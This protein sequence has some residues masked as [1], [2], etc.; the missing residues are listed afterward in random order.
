MQNLKKGMFF[1]TIGTYSNFIVQ[2]IVNMVLSRLLVPKDYG[3]VAIMQIFIIFF[4][5]MIETGMGPAII[6][7]KNLSEEDYK[8]IFNYSAIFALIL[9]VL[10]GFLGQ[11]L[12]IIYDNP[13]YQIIT[14][15]Q[16]IA[17]FFNGLNIVPTA[18]LNKSMKF[19]LVNFS[20]VL[21][22][23]FSAIVGVSS[24][25]LGFGIYSLIF[26]SITTAAFN[27]F[28][29][30]H[31]TKINFVNSLNIN[32]LK[33]I[34][35]FSKNQ[36]AFNFINYFSRNLDNI[37]I[38]KFMGITNLA[39]YNKA[40]QLLMLP[41]QMFLNVINPVLQPVL[42]EYQN[43]VIY[44]RTTY[45]KIIKLLAL[46]GIPLSVFCSMSSRQII[47][48]MFGGQ[49]VD[50]VIPF[51]ILSLTV[52]CQLTVSTT[53]AIFQARNQSN[54]LFF[55]GFISAIILVSSILIG[56]LFGSLTSVAI[57]LSV[58]FFIGFFWN[59]SQLIIKSL[60]GSMWE[61]LLL[62][63]SPFFLSILVFIAIKF[64]NF[65]DPKNFFLSLLFRGAIFS[66][67][68]ILYILFTPEKDNVKI[69][70]NK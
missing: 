63:K 52:W 29:N 65:F 66:G 28:L 37:L 9:S 60:N 5:L 26:S 45:F 55:T 2:L 42:S 62:F 40:Y 69:L 61:F 14:W 50:A 17:V 10:F 11:I 22:N 33:N 32:P 30:R 51:S 67:V 43:D 53:G 1:T 59:F 39:N 16:A 46:F 31:F 70:W 20:L 21:S 54:L 35:N 3:V 38:G 8:V 23:I 36:F 58:G 56:I 12:V 48:V 34:W 15:I 13:I 49:W 44:I 25:L 27:F 6:Q 64:E 68:T 47:M 19:K 4:N 7:N 41:N 18:L 24:A 57:S